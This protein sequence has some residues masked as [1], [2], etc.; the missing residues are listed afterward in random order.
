LQLNALNKLISAVLIKM[1]VEDQL[2]KRKLLGWGGWNCLL[3]AFLLSS[4]AIQ[5]MQEFPVGFFKYT[6][7]FDVCTCKH[8][9]TC[10]HTNTHTQDDFELDILN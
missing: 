8:T 2:R 1:L 6:Q 10:T 3:R 4:T 5:A 9:H 7:H